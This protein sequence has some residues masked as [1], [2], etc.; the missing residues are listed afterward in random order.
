M[1]HGQVRSWFMV[2]FALMIIPV[3]M[4]ASCQLQSAMDQVRDVHSGAVTT[5]RSVDTQM[6]TLFDTAGDVCI[7]QAQDDELTGTVARE[8][9]RACMESRGWM[10]VEEGLSTI[11]EV[12]AELEDIYDDIEEGI[13]RLD[14][15]KH[16]VSRLLVHGRQLV[17]IIVATGTDIQDEF[18]STLDTLCEVIQCEEN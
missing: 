3:I 8:A 2:I 15:W 4:G 1:M 17:T 14:D 16:V 9:A 6:A 11:R 13:D 10:S 12:L 18:I 5:F 7:Q